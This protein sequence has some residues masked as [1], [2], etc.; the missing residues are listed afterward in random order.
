MHILSTPRACG[1]TT[2]GSGQDAGICFQVARWATTSARRRSVSRFEKPWLNASL[3]N[4]LRHIFASLLTGADFEVEIPF[5]RLTGARKSNKFTALGSGAR[6][7][8]SGLLILGFDRKDCASDELALLLPKEKAAI[9]RI[10]ASTTLKV[11]RSADR[12]KG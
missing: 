1:H 11:E 8:G 10:E 3:A 5:D 12:G 4:E 6:V 7:G 9:E 2:P